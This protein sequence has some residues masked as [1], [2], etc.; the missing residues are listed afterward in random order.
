M[1]ITSNETDKTVKTAN[2]P[3]PAPSAKPVG[4]K[5]A[6]ESIRVL[7]DEPETIANTDN[8]QGHGPS[9]PT[10]TTRG[11]RALTHEP[12]TSKTTTDWSEAEEDDEAAFTRSNITAR[13]PKQKC[14]TPLNVPMAPKKKEP[15]LT[16]KPK[17]GN[18][19]NTAQSNAQSNES[20]NETIP[21]VSSPGDLIEAMRKIRALL[22]QT[23]IRTN[24]KKQAGET[25]D[26]IIMRMSEIF[27][28]HQE[29]KQTP[30]EINTRL[31]NIENHLAQLMKTA[32]EPPQTYAQAVRRNTTSPTNNAGNPSSPP[33]VGLRKRIEKAKQERMNTEVIL[34]ARN[35][36]DT[37]KE[38]LAN[39][40][41][42]A[43]MKSFEE[44]IKAAGMEH[45]KIRRIQKTFNHG[46]KIRCAT[47]KEAEEL[48]SMNWE[49]I[50]EGMNT[51]EVLHRVVIH[52]VSKHDTNFKKDKPEE[53]IARIPDTD[54]KKTTAKR[55]EPLLKNPRNPDAPTHSIIISFQCPKEANDCLNK[56]IHFEDRHYGIT[57]RY[58]P[59]CQL[60]QCFNCQ[61]Y[62]HKANV[63]TKKVRCGKCAQE[64]MTRECQSEKR[65]C[66]NCKD[67]HCAW[68]HECPIRQRKKEEG[69]VLRSQLSDLHIS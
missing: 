47:D 1:T 61:G 44:A 39:M 41:E 16:T 5:T 13:T 36:N 63:C 46:L 7:Q 2:R 25:M 3:Q 8:A 51:V 14:C 58:M 30:T 52:G 6:K 22:S 4:I 18:A 64:H 37:T 33:D 35:A 26:M 28:E 19:T 50:F 67:S 15:T 62:G 34:T 24:D 55:I 66:V 65:T 29:E 21:I 43:L 59:Q 56:G 10:M 27:K 11:K 68:S 20:S 23:T 12:T 42:E 45:I 9:Q 57:E 69:E 48:R 40:S 38:Q 32:M 60:K 31:S 17:D 53:I 49:M 54:S